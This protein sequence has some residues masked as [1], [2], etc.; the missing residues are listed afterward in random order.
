MDRHEDISEAG[1]RA[2]GHFTQLREDCGDR[3]AE[4]RTAL[5]TS[6][7]NVGEQQHDLLKNSARKVAFIGSR[8]GFWMLFACLAGEA[9]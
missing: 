9:R 5:L 7:R 1:I 2:Q 8:I 6:R 4:T 3:P